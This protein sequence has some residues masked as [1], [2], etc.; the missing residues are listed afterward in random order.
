VQDC[1]NSTILSLNKMELSHTN[2][3]CVML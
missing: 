2:I 1:S 3:S